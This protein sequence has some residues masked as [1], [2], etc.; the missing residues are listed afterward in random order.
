MGVAEGNG[1]N[2][3]KGV[4][5]GSTV[6]KMGAGVTVGNGRSVTA[7]VGAWPSNGADVGAMAQLHKPNPANK[8]SLFM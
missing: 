1:V 7:G 4:S 8:M 5:V 2:V 6:R 3:G